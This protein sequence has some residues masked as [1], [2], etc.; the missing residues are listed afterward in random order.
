MLL[1]IPDELL[2][3]LCATIYGY[4]TLLVLSRTNK[5][6]HYICVD[7]I[8]WK[9]K[10]ESLSKYLKSKAHHDESHF[11]HSFHPYPEQ[12]YD[13]VKNQWVKKDINYLKSFVRGT[14]SFERSGY[15]HLAWEQMEKVS[16]TGF[17]KFYF[18]SIEAVRSF[19]LAFDCPFT[20]LP[21]PVTPKSREARYSRDPH[22]WAST[23]RR[24]I[25]MTSWDPFDES[26][27]V[28]CCGS[29]GITGDAVIVKRVVDYLVENEVPTDKCVWEG[30]SWHSRGYI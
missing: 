28:G 27:R 7:P 2:V 19:F 15:H 14:W 6:L 10:A 4:K 18:S 5:K 22:L 12:E 13:E 23:D 11:Q 17:D 29:L 30:W 20:P 8:L 9:N 26:W 25:V 21:K 3:R 24:L 16:E 1:T